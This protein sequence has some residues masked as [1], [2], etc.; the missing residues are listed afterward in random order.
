MSPQDSTDELGGHADG[1]SKADNEWTK[2]YVLGD[3]A[4]VWTCDECGHAMV[5]KREFQIPGEYE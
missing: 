3:E 1:C 4:V 2:P 5:S